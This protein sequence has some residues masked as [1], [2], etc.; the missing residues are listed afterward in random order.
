[1][2]Q[3]MIRRLRA[4]FVGIATS[5]IFIILIF[6]ICMLNSMNA[7]SNY[8]EVSDML[9]YLSVHA[10]T[11]PPQLP[12]QGGR[13]TFRVTDET[14]Y[15]MRYFSVVTDTNS[16]IVQANYDHIATVN[17]SEAEE[18]TEQ[19]MSRKR[20]KGNIIN[21]N[22]TYAYLT[23]PLSPSETE[24]IGEAAADGCS[25]TVFL[26][27]TRRQ[28]HQLM[29]VQLS[30]LM[31]TLSLLVFF[32]IVSLLSRRA[33]QPTIRAYEKQR[34]FI[35]NAGHELKTP[36]AVISAN[37]EVIEMT[38]GQTEWTQST[39]AQVQRLSTLVSRLITIAKLDEM[40]P[41]DLDISQDTDL[42][43]V[44][45]E[46]CGT[47]DPLIA[48]SGKTI[49]TDIAEGITVKGDPNALRELFSILLDNAVKYC[50]EGGN[51]SLKLA[52]VR[53]KAVVTVSNDLVNG[54]GTDPTKFFDRFYRGEESHNS[55]K[56]GFGIGLSMAQSITDIH[57][58][59]IASD[60]SDGQIHFT[61]TL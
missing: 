10:G 13:F 16:N 5:A 27:C 32:I 28:Y 59:T 22:N 57:K 40:E 17:E 2:G 19:V 53:K 21:D 8:I 43:A 54:E 49:V 12:S 24:T 46:L 11:M 14:P 52:S 18:M 3:T 7:V 35:T 48:Q 39:L 60:W 25:L 50:D 38:S 33:I 15:E 20:Q 26:D 51:I 29:M 41:A 1:M 36:L 56:P 4:R 34:E 6:V 44:L 37:T 42:S 45:K 47:F 9:T 30:V 55:A 58:G 23:R 61:V 31:G